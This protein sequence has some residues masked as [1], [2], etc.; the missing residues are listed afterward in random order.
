[1]PLSESLYNIYIYI[2]IFMWILMHLLKKYIMHV[3]AR[4]TFAI[5]MTIV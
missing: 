2:C 1:M 4:T 3:Y 5:C